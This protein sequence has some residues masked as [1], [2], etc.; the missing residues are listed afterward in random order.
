MVDMVNT[1]NAPIIARER[2]IAISEV[3]HDRNGKY[4]T[5][6]RLTVTTE[7]RIRTFAG[8]LFSGNKPRI[9]EINGIGLEAELGPHML[10]TV[11]ADRPGF[12]GRL[13]STLGD[14]GV[15]IATFHLGR[16]EVGGNA[17]AMIQIDEPLDD[18]VLDSVRAL[19][20]VVQARTLKF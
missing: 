14:A 15:N 16:T 4:Q 5:L 10:Y 13:G 17:V 7:N 12:I 18:V 1:V 3:I 2:G 20:D 8:T 6:L 11:N 9:V 19:P